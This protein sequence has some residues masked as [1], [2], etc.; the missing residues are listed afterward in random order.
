MS[1]LSANFGSQVRKN[2]SDQNLTI[3]D[4]EHLSGVSF[5]YISKIELGRFEPTTKMIER[6]SKALG[7]HPTIVLLTKQKSETVEE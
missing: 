2:R 1:D 6:L 4:L 7:Y 5:Q 3:K